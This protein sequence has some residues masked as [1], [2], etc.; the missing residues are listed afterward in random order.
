[1]ETK[2]REFF[3]GLIERFND[4]FPSPTVKICLIYLTRELINFFFPDPIPDIDDKL[5]IIHVTASNT[6]LELTHGTAEDDLVENIRHEVRLSSIMPGAKG[7]IL[8]MIE[9]IQFFLFADIKTL[10]SFKR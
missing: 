9:H 8:N 5:Y 10:L 6:I 1:M 2:H 7:R 3:T 4:E